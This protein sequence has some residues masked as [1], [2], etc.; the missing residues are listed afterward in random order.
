MNS[1]NKLKIWILSLVFLVVFV[2]IASHGQVIQSNTCGSDTGASN[3]SAL[4]CNPAPNLFSTAFC[5]PTVGCTFDAIFSNIIKALLGLV[6]VVALGFVILGGYQY[7]TSGANE[8][9]ASKGKK[10]LT[11][12]IIGLIIIILSYIIITVTVN[13]LYGNIGGPQQPPNDCTIC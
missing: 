2:P 1:T 3:N 6:G 5:D 10:T 11:N 12:A 7:L 13:A 4:V 8:E 9:L